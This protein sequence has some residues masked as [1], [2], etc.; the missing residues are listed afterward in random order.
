MANPSVGVKPQPQPA[1]WQARPPAT[2]RGVAA[3][4][5]PSRFVLSSPDALGVKA[6]AP[7][8]QVD[9][10][11][12]QTRLERLRV[13]TYKKNTEGPG[14]RVTLHL[15]TANPGLVQPVEAVAETEAAA[16]LMALRAAE[17]WA[18]NRR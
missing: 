9:W 10:S 7:A 6:Q 5:G 8:V 4:N 2:A 1:S 11:A 13:V 18:Q 3:D 15:A 16:A 14:V 17:T 12:I